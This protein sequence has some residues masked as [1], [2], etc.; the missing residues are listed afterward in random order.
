MR[1]RNLAFISLFAF[2][3]S[4][5]VVLAQQP[6]AQQP[7]AQPPATQQ[8]PA[9]QPPAPAQPAAPQRPPAP[10]FVRQAQ[11]QLRD[12]HPDQA[13]ATYEKELAASPN[14]FLAH[15]GAGVVLDLMGK[16]AD[17]RKH[18]EQ[19]IAAASTPEQKAQGQRSMAM[20]Y[21]FENDCDGA[22][23]YEA[24]LY[25][26]Y[27]SKPDYYMAGE[28]AN[29]LARVCLEAGK[30]DTAEKWYR[31]GY[32]AGMQEPDIKPA[33]K[34]LW[35][36][37][38]EHAQA[39]IAARRGDKEAAAK[40]VEAAK[41]ALATG[42]NKDQEQFLPY[43]TGYVALY[44]GDYQAA[45]ADLQKANQNDPFILA[46]IAQTYEKLGDK[47]QA[48]EYYRKALGSNAHNPP[49]AYAHPLAK[50]KLGQS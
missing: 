11:Q 2:A 24:P 32:A 40:H 9:Q 48:T 28:I 46:L 4:T 27:L 14:S 13:L 25:E 34:D 29:E 19:A 42:T 47:A 30:F 20:S 18:F 45:L 16:Y 15:N 23:K 41:A 21:A 50:R 33:R 38:W 39:R 44:T 43:L 37:R 6:P 17:A 35:N 36:F 26:E 1:V 8:P 5:S 10:E 12:G 49:N 3:C 31:M 7:P 22:A